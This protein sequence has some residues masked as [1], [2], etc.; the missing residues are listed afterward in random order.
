MNAHSDCVAAPLR[1]YQ[2]WREWKFVLAGL[3]VF[4]PSLGFYLDSVSAG[5]SRHSYE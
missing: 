4:L 1:L 2:V 5:G 3:V